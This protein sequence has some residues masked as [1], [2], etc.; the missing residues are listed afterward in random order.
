MII[1]L[2]YVACGILSIGIDR[3]TWA[4]ECKKMGWPFLED[5]GMQASIHL[6]LG[7]IALLASVLAFLDEQ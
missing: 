5:A 4:L 7:P 1:T 3:A 6:T 2:A